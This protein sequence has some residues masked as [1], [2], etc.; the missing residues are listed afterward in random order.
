[1]PTPTP[2]P[3]PPSPAPKPTPTPSCPV[4]NSHCEW[5][6]GANSSIAESLS[7]ESCCGLCANTPWCEKWVWQPQ[8]KKIKH[9]VCHLHDA[10]AMSATD[11]AFE[12]VCGE[13]T[14][15]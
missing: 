12:S 2:H 15:Q 1:M 10:T 3:T 13:T 7:W 5:K 14:V 9:A 8:P 6:Y 4:V 11:P